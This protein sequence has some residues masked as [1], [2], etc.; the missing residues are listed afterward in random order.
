MDPALRKSEVIG[1]FIIFAAVAQ[2][3]RGDE[4]K[5]PFWPDGSHRWDPPKRCRA[6]Y[7]FLGL[8]DLCDGVIVTA[9]ILPPLCSVWRHAAAKRAELRIP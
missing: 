2:R 5:I 8:V 6:S 9:I 7:N 1:V 3:Q 4:G